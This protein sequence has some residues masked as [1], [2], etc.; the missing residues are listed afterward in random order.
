MNKIADLYIARSDALAEQDPSMSVTITTLTNA[1]AADISLAIRERLKASGEIG[2]D[3]AVQRS[4]ALGDRTPIEEDDLWRRVEK[5][6]S[7]KPYKALAIDL[8]EKGR[9]QRDKAIVDGLKQHKVLDDAKRAEAERANPMLGARARKAFEEGLAREAISDQRGA[10]KVLVDE[11]MERL[12]EAGEL[13][14]EHLRSLREAVRPKD[15]APS[16]QPQSPAQDDEPVARPPSPSM[17]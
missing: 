10:L 4:R 5:D 16:H 13:L 15:P 8:L 3:A 17:R 11:A 1:E 6:A 14:A 9:K 2:S 12:R 7:E